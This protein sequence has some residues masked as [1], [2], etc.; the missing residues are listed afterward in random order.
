[1][2]TTPI[3]ILFAFAFLLQSISANGQIDTTDADDYYVLRP[4]NTPPSSNSEHE[5]SPLIAGTAAFLF[6]FAGYY[7]VD[8]TQKGFIILAAQG[9]SATI[10][11]I[12][13][14]EL[15]LCSF[16]QSPNCQ[17][18]GINTFLIGVGLYQV[19]TLYSI[20]D[21][22]RIARHKNRVMGLSN[23]KYELSP[24]ISAVNPAFRG[25]SPSLGLSLRLSF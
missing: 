13:F 7:V 12:G 25:P 5:Y 17:Q 6:P 18:R 23:V 8:E 14:F 3:L 11:F 22:V 19:I 24:T 2:K 4:T 10:S 16:N 9:I 1:M 15:V 21:V 20:I